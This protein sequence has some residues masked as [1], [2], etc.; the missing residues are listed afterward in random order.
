MRKRIIISIIILLV[1]F[2]VYQGFF[3]KE[4]PTFNLAEVVRGEIT[5]EVS[6]TGQVKKGEE[7]NLSF[8]NA[9]RIEK[10]YVEVGEKVKE[11]D[12]LAKLDTAPLKIQLQ[13]AKAASD[14]ARAKLNKLSAGPTQEE[15]KIAQTAVKNSQVALDTARQGLKDAG[16]DALNVLDDSYLKAYNAFNE[17]DLIQRTYFTA[18]DQEGIKVRENKDKTAAGMTQAKS[19]LDIAKADSTNEKINTS[20]SEMKKALEIASDALKIIRETCEEP[21][22]RNLVSSTNKTSL[23]THRGYINTAITNL[24]NS[25]QLIISAK[26]AIE[27]AE[28]VLQA[29]EDDLALT[30]APARQEDI[31]LYQAQVAQAQAQVQLLENQ[32]EEAVLVS[33]TNGQI[34]KIAKQVGE[35]VQSMTGDVVIT[36]LPDAPFQIKANIYEEDVI[37]MKIG[38]PADI[39]F[40]AFP[41]KVF[42]GK[43]ISIDP[44]E[45]LIEGVVYYEVTI[46][47]EEMPEGLK[48]GMTTDLVIKTAQKENVLTVPQDAIQN[49]EGKTIVEVLKGEKFEEREIEIGLKGSNDIVEV[50]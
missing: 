46:A 9:G 6:E 35:N 37:K 27:S 45:K 36:L 1:V 44:A 16:E 15:I 10:I 24:A 25:Q 26:F 42:K 3:K 5:Q 17:V 34:T 4:R 28:G 43:I 23:D 39:S 30:T 49:K 32:I 19:Y 40:V 7:I 38:N 12:I 29:A 8:K 13:E 18:D 20:L 31:D 41:E 47:L 50:I 33:P 48:P 22:Y 14:I 21:T 11:G 2:G